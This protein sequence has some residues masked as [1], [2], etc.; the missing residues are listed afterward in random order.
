MGAEPVGGAAATHAQPHALRDIAGLILV[1]AGAVLLALGVFVPLVSAPYVGSVTFLTSGDSPRIIMFVAAIAAFVLALIGWTRHALWAGILGLAVIAYGYW[2]L[3][4]KI[5]EI[6]DRFGD[7]LLGRLVRRG[8]N[9]IELEW[10]WAVIVLG[11][12][13]IVIGGALAWRWPQRALPPVANRVMVVVGTVLVAVGV[14]L[15]LIQVPRI[16]ML[17]DILGSE[18]PR[19]LM[20][21]M[22]M[23]AFALA[24]VD[25][26]RHA[27]WPGLAG[28][29][30]LGVAYYQVL[31]NI[32]RVQASIENVEDRF[33]DG[34]FGRLAGKAAGL[35]EDRLGDAWLDKAANTA[36]QL[37]QLEWGWA[38]LVIGTAL[39]LSGSALAWREPAGEVA[40]AVAA[41]APAPAAATAPP[42]PM[43]T[44]L[45]DP[46]ADGPEIS[47][48]EPRE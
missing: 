26:T 19:I 7:G 11:A 34:W 14:F 18:L 25:W 28:A 38:V 35:L 12:M 40:P 37:I 21:V 44:E 31:A 42:A 16:A 13:L 46:S 22:A 45:R 43:V 29:V 41:P 47:G 3:Q 9:L 39:I 1:L 8:T 20:F 15:P 6:R 27:L 30:A 24:L 2:R 36:T 23:A 5:A 17:T 4:D 33:G 10:G 48:G 32:Q